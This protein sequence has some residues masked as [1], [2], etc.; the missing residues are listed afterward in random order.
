MHVLMPF[1][2]CDAMAARPDLH[3]S[4][5]LFLF[6]SSYLSL[7]FSLPFSRPSFPFFFWLAVR[8]LSRYSASLLARGLRASQ[9]QY[10]RLP[11]V[12]RQFVRGRG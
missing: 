6:H 1:T 12:I 2:L 11:L 3:C 5:L 8:A 4:N 7:S 10:F 9:A